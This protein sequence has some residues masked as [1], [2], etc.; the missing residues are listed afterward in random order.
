MID[1]NASSDAAAVKAIM[2]R[3]A[4]NSTDTAANVANT[5]RGIGFVITDGTGGQT[6]PD[7]IFV[8]INAGAA[9]PSWACHRRLGSGGKRTG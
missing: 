5:E 6:E 7:S 8:D 3:L 1:F 2:E 9:A 4:Y